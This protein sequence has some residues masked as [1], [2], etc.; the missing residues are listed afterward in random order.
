[1]LFFVSLISH[2]PKGPEDK[3]LPALTTLHS[4]TSEH[5]KYV[6]ELHIETERFVRIHTEI[7]EYSKDW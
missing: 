3:C 4:L 7:F 5:F 2:M 1:M 6:K